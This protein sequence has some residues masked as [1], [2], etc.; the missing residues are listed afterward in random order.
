MST[1]RELGEFG[2][3][4]RLARMVAEARLTAPSAADFRLRL[5]IGDDAAAW[6]VGRGVEVCTTDTLVEG[7]HFTRQT[8]PWPDLGWKLM[9]E[10]LSDIAAMG[11]TPLH[12][13]V[14]L[15]LP[16]DLPVAD[17]DGLYAGMLEA[18]RRYETLVVGGDIVAAP[19]VFLSATL[20]GVTGAEPLTR[21]AARPGDAIAVTGPLGASAG[22]LRLLQSG[23]P[24]PGG[25][26]AARNGASGALVSA[27]RRP[28]P[29]LQEGQR[30]LRA[31]IRCAMDI[32][33]GLVADLSKLC[34][35]SG[36][37]AQVYAE[38]VP[39]DPALREA[40]PEQA[41]QLA[42]NG[43]EEYQLL[44]TGPPAIVHR[45]VAGLPIGSV[46]GAITA[47]EPGSVLVMDAS[48]R[49]VPVTASGWDH[50]R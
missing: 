32:S 41:A 8:T 44:F 35:A 37:A 29:R 31:G 17:V 42:L 11:A 14:T 22:G 38:Q 23:P 45:V 13:T 4:D 12:A 9:A 21:T 1:V 25:K 33:D 34:Y 7:T 10:N 47:D 16:S 46:I 19:V 6:S 5:G 27:H 39:V 43:G 3:I 20:T 2:L 30:L 36:V 40:L 50:L 48:G 15:G 18:C 24:G 49:E 26:E 28:E